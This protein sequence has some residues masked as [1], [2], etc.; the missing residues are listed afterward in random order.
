MG[1]RPAGKR[2]FFLDISEHSAG[3]ILDM[4]GVKVKWEWTCVHFQYDSA[5]G[6]DVSLFRDNYVS[7]PGGKES[8]QRSRSAVEIVEIFS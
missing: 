7:F 2:A 5:S 8:F 3:I 4:A 1:V 6:T